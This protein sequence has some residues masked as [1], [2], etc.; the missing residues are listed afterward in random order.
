MNRV[1]AVSNGYTIVE[2][3]IFLAVSG[4][5]FLSA[6]F[7]LGGQQAR[8][9]FATGIKDI[10]SKLTDMMN[11]V[12]TGY[13]NNATDFK[14]VNNS[15]APEVTGGANSLGTNAACIYVGKALQFAPSDYDDET[16]A[17]YTL[18][19]VRSKNGVDATSLADTS[20]KVLA[21]GTYSD[22]KMKLP[23]GI[24]IVKTN[25]T[26]RSTLAFVTRFSKTSNGISNS[27]DID[28]IPVDTS[29][30]S[31]DRATSKSKIN[32]TTNFTNEV[33]TPRNPAT[34]VKLC[35]KSGGTR[36]SAEIT[37]G[38]PGRQIST[39]V[40]IYSTEDCT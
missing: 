24:K 23:Y 4:L 8:N 21:I 18:I 15:N 30:L 20:P 39:E 13:Y 9:E 1:G 2:T 25:P 26:N 12:S 40:K 17:V 5:M 38:G 28:L 16:V 35:F 22:E 10:Q 37:I 29:L 11:D 36:Q 6:M 32:D 7:F 14:C 34:G 31:T 33:V 27:Q 19:G 3:M